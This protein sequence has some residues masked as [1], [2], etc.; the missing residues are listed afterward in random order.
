M[1]NFDEAVLLR[2]THIQTN[3]RFYAN[4]LISVLVFLLSSSHKTGVTL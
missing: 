1:N 3:R 2:V 4:G